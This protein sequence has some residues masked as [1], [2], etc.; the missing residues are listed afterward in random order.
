MSDQL[1]PGEMLTLGQSI[2]SPNGQYSF[3]LLSNGD[4]CLY[5]TNNSNNPIWDAGLA[6]KGIESL[7][8]QTDG[9][10]VGY[11]SANHPVW[12]TNTYNNG[13]AWCQILDSGEVAIAKNIWSQGNTQQVSAAV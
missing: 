5:P 4:I 10:L 8:M 12:A 1:D 2:T 13:G 3:G 11:D 9:N 6:G 7:M